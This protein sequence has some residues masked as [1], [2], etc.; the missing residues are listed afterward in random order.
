VIIRSKTF[1]K[2]RSIRAVKGK[3]R[4]IRRDII[5]KAFNTV[6]KGIQEFDKFND[7]W[8]ESAW[9]IPIPF[10][11]ICPSCPFSQLRLCFGIILGGWLA[12]R[13]PSRLGIF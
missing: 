12:I 4:D 10:G 7:Q 1:K 5:M 6:K 8:Y 9:E 13:R 2:S 3:W 11:M